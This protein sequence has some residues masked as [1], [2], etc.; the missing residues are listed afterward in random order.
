MKDLYSHDRIGN[1]FNTAQPFFSIIITTY[2]RASLIPRA[3]DSLISQ[4]DKDWEAIIVDDESTDDTYLRIL[5]YLDLNSPIRYFKKAHSGEALSKNAGIKAARGKFISFLDSDDEYYPFH[6]QSR[7]QI[8]ESNTAVK[9]LYGG[10][11]IIG[12]QYVPD[13]NNCNKLVNLNECV[14][15][16]TFFVEKDLLL[17]LN[18]FRDI[19][20]GTDADLFDRAAIAGAVMKETKIP[21]YIYHH[22]NEDSITNI[23]IKSTEQLESI[24]TESIRNDAIL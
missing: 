8:L 23:L 2:N 4:T 1:K 22:E 14:I 18:G 6:L 21:S 13:K 7:K 15:G 24:F 9:L 20:L 19:I 5:P 17:R 11:K 16:G 12:N 10:V 3:I